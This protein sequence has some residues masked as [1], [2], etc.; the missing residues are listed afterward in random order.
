[1]LLNSKNIF[2]EKTFSVTEA[3]AVLIYLAMSGFGSGER[4]IG[5]LTIYYS[6]MMMSEHRC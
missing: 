2:V 6:V 3:F 4:Q 1:M 5:I